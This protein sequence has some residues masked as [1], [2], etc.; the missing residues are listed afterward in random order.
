MEHFLTRRHAVAA[1][2]RDDYDA[3][4]RVFFAVVT[5]LERAAQHTRLCMAAPRPPAECA[6]TYRFALHQLD[7]RARVPLGPSTY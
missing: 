4:Q 3:Q 7:Q 5:A 6:R 1:A 2:S